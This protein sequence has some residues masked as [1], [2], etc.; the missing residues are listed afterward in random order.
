MNKLRQQQQLRSSQLMRRLELLW[1]MQL[2]RPEP[3]FLGVQLLGAEGEG[4]RQL[5]SE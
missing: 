5:R 3:E 1:C 2:V 4:E